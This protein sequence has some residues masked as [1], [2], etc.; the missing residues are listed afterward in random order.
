[1]PE[2]PSRFRLVRHEDLLV[3]WAH[4]DNLRPSDDGARLER[5]DPAAP[6]GLVLELGSQ[7][8]AE[9]AFLET[10]AGASRAG[11]PPVKALAAGPSRLAFTLP[12]A[13]ADLPLS[14]E[15]LLVWEQLQPSLAPNALPP[16]AT[17]GAA[18]ALP[19]ANQTALELPY[20]LVLSPDA[21]ARWVHRSGPFAVA[22]RTELWHT[23]LAGVDVPLRAV[24]RRAPAD[25][26]RSS[27]SD[28]DLDDIVT[29]SSDFTIRPRSAAELGMR[30]EV[31]FLLLRQAGLSGFR[32]RTFWREY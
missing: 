2:L 8:V 1:M 20:R 25:A 29:L 15:G 4:L 13:V 7:H 6:A 14:V 9:E 11:P 31:W 32:Y 23:R 3:L 30:I 17:G 26:F 21:S 24:G 22:G 19:A 28:R 5:V 16:D 10:A 27:L 12:E 18:P